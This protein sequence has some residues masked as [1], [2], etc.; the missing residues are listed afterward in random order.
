MRFDSRNEGSNALNDLASDMYLVLGEGVAR[1]QRLQSKALVRTVL[2]RYCGAS[3]APTDLTFAYGAHGKPSLAGVVRRGVGR[4]GGDGAGGG[5]TASG[6]VSKGVIDGMAASGGVTGGGA[7]SGGVTDGMAASGGVTGGGSA[8][9]GV[10]GGR[11]QGDAPL[12]PLRFS[13]SHCSRLVVLAVTS[14]PPAAS[15][16]CLPTAYPA[17]AAASDCLPAAYPAAAAAH[18]PFWHEIGVDCE[19]GAYTRS[20]LSS[21]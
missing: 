5:V 20:R 9:G 11:G 18:P 6:A 7:A 16:D 3:V 21:T 10:T 17:A 14:A 8:S 4:G 13:L 19:A 12:L 1:I 2:A 15:S